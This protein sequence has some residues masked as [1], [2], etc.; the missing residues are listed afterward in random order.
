MGVRMFKYVCLCVGV[1][2]QVDEVIR[3]VMFRNACSCNSSLTWRND[4]SINMNELCSINSPVLPLVWRA[5]Q[6]S[7]NGCREFPMS[8]DSRG[9][10]AVW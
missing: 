6:T 8:N 7:F 2:L 1:R 5:I 10:K 4:V 3:N 9:W